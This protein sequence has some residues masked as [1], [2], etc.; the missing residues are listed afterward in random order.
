MMY[1]PYSHY[2]HKTLTLLLAAAIVSGL[3]YAGVTSALTI[4]E[5]C[6][7]YKE[8]AGPNLKKLDLNLATEEELKALPGV[9]IKTAR[10]IVDHRKAI[11]GYKSLEQLRLVRGV[12][13]KLYECLKDLVFVKSP[14]LSA[15]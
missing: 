15:P 8:E 1:V 4:E 3:T 12:G 6:Q 2:S 7:A 9:G 10:A 13:D 5:R 11:G 14:P